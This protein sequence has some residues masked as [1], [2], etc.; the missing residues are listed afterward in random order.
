MLAEAQSDLL[1]V[2]ADDVRRRLLQPRPRIIVYVPQSVATFRTEIRQTYMV[3][4]QEYLRGLFALNTLQRQSADWA[5]RGNGLN[6][7]TLAKGVQRAWR[8]HEVAKTRG[9]IQRELE[10]RQR[11]SDPGKH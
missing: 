1:I 5:S 9:E 10:A 4:F 7:V 11:A 3:D 8:D 2:S 6:L